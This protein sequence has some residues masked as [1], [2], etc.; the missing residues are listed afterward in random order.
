MKKIKKYVPFMK[1]G[2]HQASTY[3]LNLIFIIL[4]NIIGCFVSFYLWKAVFDA[5]DT[6]S[7]M[8]FNM[9]EMTTYVFISFV[10]N[11]IIGC[12]AMTSIGEEIEDG[13]IAFRLLKPISYNLTF[14][15]QE[16]GEKVLKILFVFIPVT[17]GLEIYKYFVTGFVNLSPVHF[18]L[19][20]IS[21]VFAYL[22]NAFFNISYGFTAFFFKNLWGSKMLKDCIVNFMSGCVIPLSF[23]PSILKEIFL[24]LPFSYINFVP[25][26]IYMGKYSERMMVLLILKQ[27]IWCLVFFII[28]KILWKISSRKLC[29]Q[30][31]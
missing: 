6:S 19:Y 1:A 26:M 20:M 30:G 11:S 7:F 23:L 2:F 4:G 31:G 16:V 3:K 22:I 10:T 14:I 8:G 27:V 13:T 21:I 17:M 9:V 24:F 15:S 18:I 5:T 29:I 28:S 25:V 12:N